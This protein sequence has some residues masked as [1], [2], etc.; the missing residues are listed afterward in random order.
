M[1]NNSSLAI[2]LGFVLAVSAFSGL[3]ATASAQEREQI[4]PPSKPELLSADQLNNLVAPIALFPDPLLS[5][6]FVASTYPLEIVE[7]K[8]W[9]ERNSNLKGQSLLDAA[10]QQP[11]DPSVQALV[12]V[13]DALDKLNQDIRWTTDLGNAF[14]S[15]QAEVMSAVQQMRA[16][17]KSNERLRSTPQQNVTAETQ[18]DRQVIKIVPASPDVIYVPVYDPVY[19]WGPPVFGFYPRLHYPRYGFGF[20][21]GYDLAFYFSD[22]GGWGS[23]GWGPNWITD[24]IIINNRFFRHYD[25][26]E[27]PRGD[28]RDRNVWTH[29]PDHRL[30]V[31][32]RGPRDNGRLNGPPPAPRA[33]G[34]DNRPPARNVDQGYRSSAAPPRQI[35]QNPVRQ[36][37]QP[38]T[39]YQS[40]PRQ[41]RA[42][43]EVQ[44]YPS[45]APR[46]YQSPQYRSAPQTYRA[47]QVQQLQNR[48]QPR[49]QTSPQYRSVP[50]M[51]SPRSST[52]N[53]A[54]SSGSRPR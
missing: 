38:S 9:L 26:P 32:Y 13:P 42:T 17:A 6:M 19:I 24:V 12:A 43:P 41:Y 21:T 30:N 29:N 36:R 5:Q 18:V 34:P 48:P 51:S 40:T 20:G 3:T 50:Q 2:F 39:Q 35:D 33:S 22:W 52:G 49:M 11:W 53:S 37:Y 44:K 54:R 47:P 31:P 7:A 8:Q 10:K 25:F 4:P 46:T 45:Q 1:R 15:Q 14:L 23:W 28:F 16:R 27:R